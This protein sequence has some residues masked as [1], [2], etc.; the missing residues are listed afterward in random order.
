MIGCV[1]THNHPR[2]VTLAHWRRGRPHEDDLDVLHVLAVL[3]GRHDLVPSALLPPP[4][5][6][7]E[8]GV[9]RHVLDPEVVGAVEYLGC[10]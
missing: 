10:N 9:V 2:Y 7:A 3:V 8:L 1:N 4:P 5:L 6:D